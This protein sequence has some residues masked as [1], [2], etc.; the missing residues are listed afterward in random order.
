MNFERI[1]KEVLENVGGA[2]N[3]AHV[4][5]CVTRLRFNLKDDS[6]ADIDKIKKIKGV[7]GQVNKGGQFQVIIG[8]DVS[9]VYKELLKL[10][11]FKSSNNQEEE[12]GAKK[13]IITSVFDTIAGIFTP[14]IP[15]IAGCGMLKAF[16]GL[17]V[18]LGLI[19]TETQT[20]YIFSF[21]SDAAF[22]FMPL[23]LAYTAGIKFKTSPFLAMVIGGVLL[24]PSFSALVSAGEPV[25]FLGLPVRL[26]NYSSSVIPIILI[27]WLMSYVEKLANKFIPKVLRL[28]FVPLIVITV[29]APIGL[30][31]IG[32]L[33][34]VIG[35]VLASGIMFIDSKATWTL[36]L[37]M[38]GLTPLIV[39]TGMHYSLYPAL[40]TQLATLGYQTL[41][42]GMLISNVCQGAAA[43]CVSI[44][45]KNSELKQLASSTGITALLGITEPAMYGVNLKLKKPLYAV[46]CGGALGGL[47][48]GLT[49]VKGYTP[50]GSGLPGI[51]AY[52]GPEMSNV[53]NILIACGIGFVATFIITWFIGFED[54]VNEDEAVEEISDVK[55]LKN[56]I[57]IKSP[58]KGEAVPL[59]QVDDPT[60]AEEIMGKG[61]AIIP[62]ED[63]IFSP[64]NGTVSL[65]FNTK[66]AI[67]L[68]TEDG[69][70]VLIHI[71]LDTV[72][73][74][75]E[76]FT[77]F[78][79]SGD[80]VKVGDKLVEFDRE[81]IKNK[82]YDII[83]PII[84][85]N[86]SDYLDI[87]PKD[88]T[89][90]NQGDEV[91]AIL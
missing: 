16:L 82:G 80:K 21:I 12:K 30:I 86:S 69:A 23:L 29:T 87:I 38:G 81:A 45:S 55:A 78:V 47:Y 60:F 63:E 28:V 5:H 34:T 6:K 57:S 76:H 51:A 83:T 71:G 54:E 41:M 49:A 13:G 66:H 77:T 39:M 18:A 31:V 88:V 11:N 42:P 33:G 56:K 26:V 40:F 22:F 37:I 9:D 8:N 7:M 67:G 58:V 89:S 65:V 64:I 19:S 70:E 32:P 10:G 52:I 84:I 85:T 2:N 4:T 46:L 14:I 91:L 72:K 50:S 35:D 68:K 43:L 24:H 79:K 44:K 53:V 3:V 20:Y 36:P 48:A 62:T 73:L 61:I 75:G 59:S 25:S 74:N 27:V 90:V 1:A 17:F 15:A